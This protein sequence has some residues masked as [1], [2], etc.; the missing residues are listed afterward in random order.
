MSKC[1]ESIRKSNYL[2]FDQTEQD[3]GPCLDRKV[4]TYGRQTKVQK[5]H[6]VFVTFENS[7]VFNVFSCLQEQIYVYKNK[8][9]VSSS[10][11]ILML[12]ESLESET[13]KG[14]NKVF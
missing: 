13:N 2:V 7:I 12:L 6:K 8:Y 3:L 1:I 4:C 5:V 11:H 10:Q 9:P 14:I